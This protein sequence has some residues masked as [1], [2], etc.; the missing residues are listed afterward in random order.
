M[1]TVVTPVCAATEL[2]LL[3]L[4][5]QMSLD[6]RMAVLGTL[7]M[8]IAPIMEVGKK[9]VHRRLGFDEST[10]PLAKGSVDVCYYVATSLA[11]SLF[12][13]T[14]E[15]LRQSPEYGVYGLSDIIDTTWK[16]SVPSVPGFI[17]LGLTNATDRF[18]Q[19]FSL[20]TDEPALF[21]E[22]LIYAD[23]LKDSSLKTYSLKT[24]YI[25]EFIGKR[26]PAMR[27]AIAI[28]LITA[29]LLSLKALYYNKDVTV[30]V[31]T[32]KE[33]IVPEQIIPEAAP[34]MD[35]HRKQKR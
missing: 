15:Y 27:K 22:S 25:S 29:S 12:I 23:P 7:Y 31:P 28:A 13:A 26:T 1:G 4:H 30:H 19:L 5:P 10:H 11:G 20:K 14:F 9:A 2:Y 21:D 8:G 6:A 18:R 16:L 24:Y 17:A 35:I 33:S 32:G 34:K 3:K